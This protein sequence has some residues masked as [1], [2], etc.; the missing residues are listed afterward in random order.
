VKILIVIPYFIPAKSYGGPVTV[1]YLH[2]KYLIKLGHSVT[3]ATS[4][5][6]NS[7]ENI[8]TKEEIIDG[9][10]IIRF[11]VK[12][13]FLKKI[14]FFFSPQF[15]K[16]LTRNIK[17]FD[18]VHCHDFYT[19]QNIIVRNLS[20]KF[21]IPYLVQPHGCAVPLIP[22]GRSFIKSI[23]IF[24]FGKSIVKD[25]KSVIAITQKEKQQ[26][27][28]FY[29]TKNITILPNG[30]EPKHI[31]SRKNIFQTNN[32][33]VSSKVIFSLG[34]LHPIKGFDDLIKT[35]YYLCKLRSD[36]F[37]IIG[38]PDEGELYNLKELCNKL[39]IVSKV[40]FPGQLSIELANSYYK[41]S[42]LFSL[43]SR[44]EPFPMVILE[45]LSNNLPVLIS[46]NIEFSKK[47]ANKP[48]ATIVDPRAH[49]SNSKIINK[50]LDKP[51]TKHKQYNKF[52]KNYDIQNICKQLEHIYNNAKRQAQI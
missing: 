22:R 9:I 44:Q 42:V 52:L 34:R 26:I 4:D 20:I 47:I 28:D 14:N 38:G 7:N 31:T 51:P 35:F 15:K 48:F 45:A 8:S 2:A 41:S 18:I 25:A 29:H 50:I 36:V 5:T 43:L 16:W 3:V 27:R 11:P 40:L 12:Y 1:S 37:L 49:I 10:K 13:H 46:K 17:K 6:L 19:Y 33:P 23:F 30:F 21:K 39:N 32:I 24:I